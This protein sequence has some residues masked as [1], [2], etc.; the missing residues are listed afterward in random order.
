PVLS[1]VPSLAPH[2]GSPVTLRCQTK[3]HPQ[4]LASWLLFS[5]HKDRTL[6]GRGLHPE[7][8]IPGTKQGDSGLYWCNA[9]TEGGQVQKQ[10]PQKEIRVHGKWGRVEHPQGSEHQGP[11]DW[12]F[13]GDVVKLLCE[14]ERGS[15]PILYWFHLNGEILE[16]HSGP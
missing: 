12:L 8:W 14:P 3:L 15:P 16:N 9:D 11:G 5:F 1:I 6:Q 7:L 13:W 2:E 4:R 10:S